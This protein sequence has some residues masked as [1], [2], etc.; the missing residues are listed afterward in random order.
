MKEQSLIKIQRKSKF[1]CDDFE[2]NRKRG[3]SL[4]MYVISL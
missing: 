1:V 4:F 3:E 2:S